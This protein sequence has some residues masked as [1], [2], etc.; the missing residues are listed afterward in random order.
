M[1][2]LADKAR[3]QI[4]DAIMAIETHAH[5]LTHSL[6]SYK[7]GIGRACVAKQR[8]MSMVIEI[9]AHRLLHH[10]CK[11][12]QTSA[13]V[14][15][16]TRRPS[17]AIEIHAHKLPYSLRVYERDIERACMQYRAKMNLGPQP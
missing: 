7:G 10:D 5:E 16:R 3:T 4:D 2:F 17:M 9:H 6:R 11:K 13:R 12:Y 14:S 15:Q 1:V 8:R